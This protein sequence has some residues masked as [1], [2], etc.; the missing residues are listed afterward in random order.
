MKLSKQE[1]R[2]L[3]ATNENDNKRKHVVLPSLTKPPRLLRKANS[4]ENILSRMVTQ[5]EFARAQTFTHPKVS[6]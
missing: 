5:K 4:S 6:K 2:T 3:K 1:T